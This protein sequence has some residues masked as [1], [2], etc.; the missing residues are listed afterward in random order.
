MEP[1]CCRPAENL[2]FS[3]SSFLVS[4]CGD[5]VYS[6]VLE[7]CRYGNLSWYMFKDFADFIDGRVGDSHCSLKM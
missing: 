4:E 3:C 7:L 1:I 2:R 6:S 5:E